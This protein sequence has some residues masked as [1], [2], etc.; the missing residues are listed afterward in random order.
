MLKLYNGVTSVCSVK[1][2]IGLAEI[3]LDYED[4]RLDIQKGDQFDPDYMKLNP[5]AVVPTLIDDGL[6]LVES[7][8]ILEYLDQTYNQNRLMP[9]DRAKAVAA[10]HWLL[11]CL[12][13]HAAVNTLTHST[14]NRKRH[15]ASKTPQEIEAMI[16]RK[17]DPVSQMKRKD[18]YANGLKSPYV[19]QA[20][21]HLRS[22]FADMGKVL[23]E[24]D[25]VTGPEFGIADIA[26]ISYID[27]LERLGFRGL[28]LDTEP[29][30]ADWLA[31]MQSRQS[32]QVEVQSKIPAQMAEAQLRDGSEFWSE[33]EDR[34]RASA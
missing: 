17:P 21:M 2:R 18:L 13:I 10:R 20:L 7:S 8:L 19:S 14:V 9:V 29:R 30:V 4:Q 1:V 3:G 26:L 25:W 28:W 23:S 16:A 27:R 24:G 12:A 33:L 11:R 22:A 31:S 34:W 5:A 15:L 32:Y 6:V